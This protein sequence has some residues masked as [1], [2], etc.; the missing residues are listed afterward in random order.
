MAFNWEHAGSSLA[1][2]PIDDSGRKS[3]NIPLLHG[4]TDT[5]TDLEFSPFHDG[6]LATGSQDCL[7]SA[8]ILR[9]WCTEYIGERWVVKNCFFYQLFRSNCGISRKRVLNNRYP[10]P[11]AHFRTSNVAWKPLASIQQLIIC[12]IRRRR[13]ILICGIWLCRK[14]RLVCVNSL[15]IFFFY[16]VARCWFF[17]IHFCLANNEHPEVIQSLCWKHDGTL[18]STSC[19]D[20]IVR[21]IDP[22]AKTPIVMTADS[23]QSIKDSRV[24][25][26]GDQ[27]RILTTGKRNCIFLFV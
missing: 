18:I 8:L 7:V 9:L 19:K 25:W 16:F 22:R 20:K 10:H 27:Q 11:N 13:E 17:F 1:V 2:F 3:K 24:V 21:I 14:R 4:H 5:V 6:L 23:H 15:L 26:L 12:F